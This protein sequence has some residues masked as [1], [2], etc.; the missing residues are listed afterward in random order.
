M[1]LDID[2]SDMQ[3]AEFDGNIVE[4]LELDGVLIWEKGVEPATEGLIFSPSDETS[5]KYYVTS[6]TVYAEADAIAY[7]DYDFSTNNFV[8]R[9]LAEGD[10]VVGL[11]QARTNTYP[12]YGVLDYVGTATDVIIPNQINGNIIKIWSFS[13]G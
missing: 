6:N 1:I 7:Y 2:L 9:T 5:F 12:Y 8:E 10:S 3:T 11:Y 4:S 13:C